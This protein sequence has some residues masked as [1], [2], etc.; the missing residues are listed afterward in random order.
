MARGGKTGRVKNAAADVAKDAAKKL[1]DKAIND[2]EF[3]EQATKLAQDAAKQ[4][5]DRAAIVSETAK[6][7][8]EGATE[9]AKG[10]ADKATGLKE[11]VE[12][13]SKDR[14]EKKAA[15]IRRQQQLELLAKENNLSAVEFKESYERSIETGFPFHKNSGCYVV[16]TLKKPGA[17]LD[18][19]ASYE[20]VYVGV[21]DDLGEAVFKQLTG[22]GNV[23]VYADFKY[24]AK[25]MVIMLPSNAEGE[26]LSAKREQ[27]IEILDANESYDARELGE[28]AE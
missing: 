12:Q 23:D 1:V 14:K 19:F 25:S 22:D 18:S 17:K 5:S 20:G 4:V 16:A 3:M 28:S 11:G 6:K 26:D 9:T 15:K 24:R 2:P 13:A 27:L 10:V 8:A 21:A 7:V